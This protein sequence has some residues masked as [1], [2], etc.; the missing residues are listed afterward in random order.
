[1]AETRGS[2]IA[3]TLALGVAGAVIATD[4][5]RAHD[6][7]TACPDV[8]AQQETM[9]ERTVDADLTLEER[10]CRFRSNL[11]HGSEAAGETVA[12]MLRDLDR[13]AND[14]AHEIEQ[15]GAKART[16]ARL[17]WAALADERAALERLAEDIG[18]R[19]S[20]ALVASGDAFESAY[21]TAYQ[22]L[23]EIN[24]AIEAEIGTADS[25]QSG[26]RS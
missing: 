4:D 10:L 9:A 20:D 7:A 14:L 26:D 22:R 15:M 25:Q 12:D 24:A 6:P 18:D 8:E 5:L 3:L 13:E 2:Y 19:T 17:Q 1:M 16:E 21:R 23:R 11:A